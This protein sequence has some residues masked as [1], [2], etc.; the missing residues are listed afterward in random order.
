M[1]DIKIISNV[2]QPLVVSVGIIQARKPY[3]SCWKATKKKLKMN[4]N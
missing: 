4:N 2:I 3:V 1:F